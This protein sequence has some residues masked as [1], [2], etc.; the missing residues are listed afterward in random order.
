MLPVVHVGFHKCGSTTL[1]SALFDRHPQ[2][3]NLGEP[4]ENENALEAMRNVWESCH[5]NPRKR[6]PFDADRG[7]ALWQEALATVPPGRVPVIICACSLMHSPRLICAFASI[8]AILMYILLLP[9][10]NG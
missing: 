2:V 10:K 4:R 6:S 8:R 9:W 5:E 3:A 1:Q 7:R